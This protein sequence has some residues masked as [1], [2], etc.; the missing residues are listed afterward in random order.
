M[1][2][3]MVRRCGLSLPAGMGLA[4]MI[5]FSGP[6]HREQTSLRCQNVYQQSGAGTNCAWRWPIASS[7]R[8]YG[9]APS[10]MTAA[11]GDAATMSLPKNRVGLSGFVSLSVLG[12][13][14]DA[15][16]GHNWVRRMRKSTCHL[17]GTCGSS[18]KASMSLC[19]GW[20]IHQKWAINE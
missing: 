18:A 6:G 16:N 1:T 12:D 5:D 3:A 2:A 19:G 9:P 14:T 20:A 4:R 13:D 8:R 15:A 10:G 17:A 7:K 11:C